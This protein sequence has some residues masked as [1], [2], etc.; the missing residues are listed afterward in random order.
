MSPFVKLQASYILVPQNFLIQTLT[1]ATPPTF[2]SVIE[3]LKTFTGPGKGPSDILKATESLSNEEKEVLANNPD[4][5]ANISD[6]EKTRIGL[7]LAKMLTSDEGL[8]HLKNAALVTT[9]AI[10]ASMVMFASL[11]S[12]LNTLEYKFQ[13]PDKEKFTP[14]LQIHKDVRDHL[15]SLFPAIRLLTQHDRRSL[16]LSRQVKCWQAELQRM[17]SVSLTFISTRFYLVI[18][19]LI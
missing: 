18:D 14:D 10:E 1:M 13:V 16:R 11:G 7:A 2:E 5:V 15:L 12:Q 3:K 9:R 19:T 17:G 4:K 8:N 6:E